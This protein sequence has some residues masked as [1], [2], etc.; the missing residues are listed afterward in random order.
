MI[1]S[2]CLIYIFCRKA[3]NQ[4]YVEMW[5]WKSG[6][7]ILIRDE[8]GKPVVCIVICRYYFDISCISKESCMAVVST[9]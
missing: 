3:K 9:I 8:A 5:P 1:D 2:Y 4:P 7:E 6:A